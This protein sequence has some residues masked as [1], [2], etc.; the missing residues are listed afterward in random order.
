[1]PTCSP[2][3][4]WNNS[5][6]TSL[7]GR[8]YENADDQP[9]GTE[10]PVHSGGAWPWCGGT[11]LVD[12][13]P[14][15]WSARSDGVVQPRRDRGRC[16]PLPHL[17]VDLGGG[18]LRNTKP[19]GCAPTLSRG[20]PLPMG[21]QP[22]LPGGAA[23]RARRSLVVR[24]AIAA[25]LRGR[26]GDLLPPVRDW[27]RGADPASG[28]RPDIRRVPAQGAALDYRAGAAQLSP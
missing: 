3:S 24:L 14:Q 28:V 11:A 7:S 16:R 21:A 5:P 20:R 22:D 27:V 6:A 8:S 23:G 25:A 1:M 4:P 26:D 13:H 15:W 19:V 10:F 2:S 18:R 9:R 17:R 12:P